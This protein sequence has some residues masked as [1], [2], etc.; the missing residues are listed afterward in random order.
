MIPI[1]QQII[2]FKCA[3]DDADI[4]SFGF[5]LGT[6]RTQEI[7]SEMRFP[8]MD[9]TLSLEDWTGMYDEIREKG[10]HVLS[11]IDGTAF[12]VADFTYGLSQAQ[13]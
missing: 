13:V 6:K 3:I 9:S 4:Q 8:I 1:D 10:T 11:R 7:V 12:K 2:G 5:L